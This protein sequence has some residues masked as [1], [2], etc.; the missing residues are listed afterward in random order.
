ME[1]YGSSALTTQTNRFGEQYILELSQKLF[2]SIDSH[3]VF[4]Q[5]F[6][7]ND[8]SPESF[9]IICGTESGLLIKYFL[10]GDLPESTRIIFVELPEVIHWLKTQS[11]LPPLPK[12][13]SL[14]AYDK[15]AGQLDAFSINSYIL[16]DKLYYIP[17]LSVQYGF[18]PAYGDFSS[19]VHDYL[20][21]L[22]W[23]IRIDLDQKDFIIGQLENVAENRTPC[24]VLYSKFEG[25]TAVLLA[26]G[27]S[28]DEI[29]PWIV[30][31]REKL[32]V[33][34]VSRIARQL[35]EHNLSP[36]F[37]VTV[38]TQPV[39][40]KVSKEM[41]YFHKDSILINHAQACPQLI[42]QCHGSTCPM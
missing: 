33:F 9:Y 35:L 24:S 3:T 15:L 6:K 19:A 12:N 4:S 5:N 14:V 34:A 31:N 42:S 17:S 18:Y 20:K 1:E 11:T 27:P 7:K 2:E 32:V 30:L 29:L 40:F 22:H 8:L 10:D 13:V 39:S 28:L 21:T 36:D 16:Q 41:L 37:F 23:N 25:L 26:G 38:H